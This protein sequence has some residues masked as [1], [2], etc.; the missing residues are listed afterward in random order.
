VRCGL[1]AFLWLGLLE[2]L[3]SEVTLSGA[4]HQALLPPSPARPELPGP[5]VVQRQLW[6]QPAGDEQL[7]VRAQ[8]R[9]EVLRPGTFTAV[10]AGP[11]L[12]VDRLVAC[13]ELLAATRNEA[14]E[15][16]LAVALEQSCTIE[17]VGH[18]LGDPGSGLSLTLLPAGSGRMEHPGDFV[19]Q[20][21]GAVLVA[22]GL[23]LGAPGEM[24]LAPAPVRNEAQGTLVL[25]ET[26]LGITVGEAE[27]RVRARL[28]W[29]ITR[30][31]LGRVSFEAPGAGEDLEVTGAVLASWHRSGD[32]VEVELRQPERS[33][34][35]LEVS[36]T[37]AAGS[38]EMTQ[39]PVPVLRPD[40]VFRTTS[41]LQLA[42]DGQLDLVPELAGAVVA[43]P[44]DLPDWGRDL[45]EGAP[46]GSFV[47][48]GAGGKVT[49]YRFTPADSPAT[50]VDVA[51]YTLSVT[52][53][54]RVLLRAHYAVRNDR[55]AALRVTPP[56]GLRP[57]GAR[58]G[59]EVATVARS[60]GDG[61]AWLVPLEKSVET[62]EGLLSFPVE[63]LF[64]GELPGGWTRKGPEG[65]RLPSV[66]AEVA[67]AR[68][69][70]H[71]PPGWKSRLRS[72]EHAV[73]DAFTEGQGITYGFAVGD[74]RAGQADM[75]FQQAVDAWMGNDFDETGQILDELEQM[76]ASNSDI[77]RL[78]SNLSVVSGDGKEKGGTEGNQQLE[79]RV[80]E[81]ARA[82]AADDEEAQ[83]EELKK[84]EEAYN[85]GDYQAAEEAYR[86][87]LEVGE[88]LAKLQADEDARQ[89][90]LN[91]VVKEKLAASQQVQKQ[92][93]AS[94]TSQS[95]RYTLEDTKV[96]GA[97][98]KPSR[99]AGTEQTAE[100]T[101]EQTVEL[102]LEE[103]EEAHRRREAAALRAPLSDT[104]AQL[105]A[106]RERAQIAA[107]A[108]AAARARALELE[109][110]QTWPA[111]TPA[112]AAP[113][114]EPPAEPSRGGWA[115]PQGPPEAPPKVPV[116]EP[117]AHSVVIT[118]TPEQFAQVDQMMRQLD[119]PVE[120]PVDG[121]TGYHFEDI[122]IRGELVA[123]EGR[124]KDH[125]PAEDQPYEVTASALSVVI[126]TQGEPVLY[127]QLLLPPGTPWEV[128]IRA[129]EKR[130]NR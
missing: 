55:G 28:R 95:N 127:Q 42:R 109:G 120:V 68:A 41:T 72:G 113:S 106:E 77:G 27:V 121:N 122:E 102:T 22:P 37:A 18:V 66:D 44:D 105:E 51:S 116:A 6:L 75:L 57:I 112:A 78:R 1:S 7:D 46:T 59:G 80:L 32:R 117:G 88:G 114:P 29:R 26:A 96:T 90:K 108:A 63:V 85:S 128:R 3:A 47:G 98:E 101:P 126:P 82:R 52:D 60:P 14:G 38:G 110:E 130:R 104:R 111:G 2:A 34:V 33:L 9:V 16:L 115:R 12:V 86:N 4:R 89:D 40:G 50:I 129:K 100:Q 84:A 119:M 64:L 103:E 73:V 67:V 10:L 74:A 93:V 19:V 48:V 69:T 39:L 8:W 99:P 13:G 53:E 81:Q 35:A 91:E 65:L 17:L 79:R 92:K 124:S 70:V 54:G 43:A 23:S 56:P 45:V 11:S 24:Q 49:V 118:G 97:V 71:L 15:L 87:A 58:V 62:V 21:P 5:L 125:E 83:K 20:G 36:Y 123:P 76:G 25:G 61:E 107:E 30:G 94:S 31:E